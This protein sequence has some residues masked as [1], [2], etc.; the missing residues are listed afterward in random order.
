NAH[1][2]T[3]VP[4]FLSRAFRHSAIFVRS[5]RVS[6]PTGLKGKRVGTPEYLTTMLVWLRGLLS[7]EYGI[8]PSDLHWR[9]GGVEQPSTK[10]GGSNKGPGAKTKTT[11]AGKP[12]PACWPTARSTRSSR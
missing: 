11:P 3:A 12:L 6:S 1:H 2:Y 9:L 8:A 5:D 10:P 7:D 4:V